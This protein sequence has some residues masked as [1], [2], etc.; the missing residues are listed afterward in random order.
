MID[1]P[2]P[3]RPLE[4]E[5]RER[6]GGPMSVNERRLVVL[7]LAILLL[8]TITA[9]AATKT[10]WTPIYTDYVAEAGEVW[11]MAIEPGP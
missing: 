2:S 10:S 6:I 7:L 1:P 9:F 8:P 4:D 3:L 11:A 5:H